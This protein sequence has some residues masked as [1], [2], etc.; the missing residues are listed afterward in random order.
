MHEV[1]CNTSPLLY[2]HQLRLLDVLPGL[3]GSS[4]TCSLAQAFDTL[5]RGVRVVLRD[6]TSKV[7]L[8]P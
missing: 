7:V 1:F 2:L 4:F 5:S 6:V 8:V 3:S